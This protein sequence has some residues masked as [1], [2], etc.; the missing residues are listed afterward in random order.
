MRKRILPVLLALALCG[1]AVPHASALFKPEGV[2]S[3]T[4]TVTKELDFQDPEGT[5]SFSNLS[6]RVRAND[7]NLRTLEE[8][9]ASIEVIDY[10]KMYEDLRKSM[11]ALAD[12][13]YGMIQGSQIILP[14]GKPLVE[15][16]SYAYA[17]LEQAYDAMR[18][19]FE[20]IKEGKLQKDN[21]GVVWQLKTAQN[22]IVM[23]AEALYTALVGL[24]LQEASLVRS[25]A[26]TDRTVEEMQLRHTLGQISALQLQQV[27]AGRASLA[28]GLETLRMNIRTYKMQLEQMLGVP[29]TGTIQL[30]PL[31]RVL[32]SQVEELDVETGLTEA[33][34]HSYALY[35]AGETLEDARETYRDAGKEYGYN[36]KKYQ[37]VAAQHTWQAAQHTYDAA[38]QTHERGF[39][40]LYLQVLDYR[41]AADAART[42]LAAEERSFA[43]AQLKHQQGSLSQNALL[44]A[45][46]KLDTARETVQK[47]EIDLF[48]AYHTYGWAVD[49]GILN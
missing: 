49:H 41:Q 29:L 13:Q 39:R 18:D 5:V 47:A 45:R 14:D 12:A 36:E 30:A 20:D 15:F 10:D 40:T 19:T 34:T 9:I 4:I 37:F 44:D 33:R 8:T 26:A 16:D 35:D 46:D 25:L 3:G 17:Q 27:T 7:R 28:S 6:R 22:Q 31:P 11:N 43:A 38:V 23:G 1:S 42:A 21:A 32:D 2:P 48:S 24:E